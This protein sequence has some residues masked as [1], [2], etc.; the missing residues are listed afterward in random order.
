MR[1]GKLS[2]G[3]LDV[4][5]D[6]VLTVRVHLTE[7][8]DAGLLLQGAL[9]IGNLRLDCMT[10]SEQAHAGWKITEAACR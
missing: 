3:Q 2:S 7:I 9:M 6:G 5:H 8:I 4:L 10:K 1:C